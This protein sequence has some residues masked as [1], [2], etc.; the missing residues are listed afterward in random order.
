MA[1]AVRITLTDQMVNALDFIRKETSP[2][3]KNNEIIKNAIS[4]YY[5]NV[6]DR[7]K[8]DDKL[9][10]ISEDWEYWVTKKEEKRIRKSYEDAQKEENLTEPMSSNDFIKYLR[11]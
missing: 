7:M 3:L 5:A 4:E 2:L 11:S 9:V 8:D 10:N 1:E 6:L